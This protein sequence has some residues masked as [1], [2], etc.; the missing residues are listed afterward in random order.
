MPRREKS[1]R[2]LRAEAVEKKGGA[3]KGCT[4][5]EGDFYLQLPNHGLPTQFNAD[6]VKVRVCCEAVGKQII[7][8]QQV[9]AP[10]ECRHFKRKRRRKAK[11]RE[12][13]KLPSVGD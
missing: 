5:R 6:N 11:K 1:E 12:A 4:Y 9:E 7:R 3:C 13:R 10:D 2:K 8:P